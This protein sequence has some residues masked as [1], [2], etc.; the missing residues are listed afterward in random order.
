ML[1]PMPNTPSAKMKSGARDKI[2][3]AV[4]DLAGKIEAAAG[5]AIGNNR[6]IIQGRVDQIEG[7][8]RKKIGEIKQVF[9]M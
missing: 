2:E 3:G 5:Q 7:K 1:L 6:L 8:V 4:K 9:G